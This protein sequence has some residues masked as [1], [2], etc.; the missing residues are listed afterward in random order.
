M[1]GLKTPRI[2][3]LGKQ[4]LLAPL[5]PILLITGTP[6]GEQRNIFLQE[7]TYCCAIRP[8]GFGVGSKR[9]ISCGVF[10]LGKSG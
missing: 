3:A 1:R 8:F 2:P 5:G 10:G 4:G 6:G 9:Y 7:M